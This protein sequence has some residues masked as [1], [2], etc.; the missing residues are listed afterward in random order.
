MCTREGKVHVRLFV[1]EWEGASACEKKEKKDSSL[2]FVL[3]SASIISS[4]VQLLFT[5]YTTYNYLTLNR[6]NKLLTLTIFTTLVV[7]IFC[8]RVLTCYQ[9]SM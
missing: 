3:S 5:K 8:E 6:S 9:H 1:R 2:V 4:T 7:R